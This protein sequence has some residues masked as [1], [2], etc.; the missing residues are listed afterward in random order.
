MHKREHTPAKVKI[1]Y[2]FRTVN[3]LSH[4]KTDVNYRALE[5]SPSPTHYKLVIV[6]LTAV[7]YLSCFRDNPFPR[8]ARV[9]AA[10]SRRKSG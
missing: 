3:L 2:R 6:P 10:S 9:R 4:S 8:S 5:L 1:K 7:E